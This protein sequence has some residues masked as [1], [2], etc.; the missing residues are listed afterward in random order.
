ML[1]Q[2]QGSSSPAWDLHHLSRLPLA[3]TKAYSKAP[4]PGVLFGSGMKAL[5]QP[6]GHAGRQ[7]PHSVL[8][9]EPSKSLVTAAAAHGRW[10][11]FWSGGKHSPT[12]GQHLPLRVPWDPHALH[13]P[14]LQDVL[15]LLADS[16]GRRAEHYC[17][18]HGVHVSQGLQAGQRVVAVILQLI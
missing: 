14:Y 9:K 10:A 15:Q 4:A 3:S 16:G 1:Q 7:V 12:S 6:Y 13:S 5:G 17:P 11:L 18:Q 8:L 2:Q